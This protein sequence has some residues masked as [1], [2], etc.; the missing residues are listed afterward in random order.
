[1]ENSNI[2]N[3]QML[4]ISAALDVEAKLIG[5][6]SSRSLGPLAAFIFRRLLYCETRASKLLDRG[7]L[8][9]T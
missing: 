8:V 3:L 6:R 4:A 9:A 7:S 1:M 5:L 2:L